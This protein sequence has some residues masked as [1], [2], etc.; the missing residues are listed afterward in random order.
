MVLSVRDKSEC[1]RGF[2]SLLGQWKGLVGFGRSTASRE[3][4]ST[5]VS[6]G[7]GEGSSTCSTGWAGGLRLI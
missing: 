4:V 6:F 7:H 1:D 3:L 5:E 2:S